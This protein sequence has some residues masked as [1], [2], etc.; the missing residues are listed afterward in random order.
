M[1]DLGAQ[2]SMKIYASFGLKNLGGSCTKVEVS[3]WISSSAHN[4]DIFPL[5]DS[6][7]IGSKKHEKLFFCMFS[8]HFFGVF[9]AGSQLVIAEI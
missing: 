7:L 2:I 6:L 4:K 9:S 8:S 5:N 3:Q 1:F